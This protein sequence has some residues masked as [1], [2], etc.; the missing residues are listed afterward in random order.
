MA[1]KKDTCPLCKI[2][3]KNNLS[4][5]IGG[6]LSGQNKYNPQEQQ[7][8]RGESQLNHQQQDG[9]GIPAEEPTKPELS[10][11]PAQPLFARKP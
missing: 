9:Q 1:S 6:I 2:N 7:H 11:M 8:G 4:P 3:V 5:S 10:I